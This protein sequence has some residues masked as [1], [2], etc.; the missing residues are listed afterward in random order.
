MKR[1]GARQNNAHPWRSKNRSDF[2]ETLR[3]GTP[4]SLSNELTLGAPQGS[5][6]SRWNRRRKKAKEKAKRGAERSETLFLD[7]GRS[8]QVI[9]G[10]ESPQGGERHG[11]VIELDGKNGGK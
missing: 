6:F 1:R 5:R 3:K 4:H 11:V 7:G 10:G 2:K 9:I 8:R